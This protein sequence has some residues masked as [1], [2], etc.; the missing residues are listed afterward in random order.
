[1]SRPAGVV[2]DVKNVFD[3]SCD[4]ICAQSSETG[5]VLSC[6]ATL[7]DRF[8]SVN[9]QGRIE[10][11]AETAKNLRDLLA[12]LIKDAD[13]S[14]SKDTVKPPIATLNTSLPEGGR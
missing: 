10:L 8:V 6:G 14:T 12:Q 4:I 13:A 11:P 5:V 7:G 9:L 3:V 2:W 1:M